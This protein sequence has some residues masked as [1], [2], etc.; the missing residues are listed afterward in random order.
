[1][2][3]LNEEWSHATD[4]L[5]RGSTQTPRAVGEPRRGEMPQE[6]IGQLPHRRHPDR[7][8]T[9][10][11][12][13]PRSR[14]KR[15]SAFSPSAADKGDAESSTD[16]FRVATRSSST[17]ESNANTVF[18]TRDMFLP[19]TSLVW[20]GPAHSRAPSA[21]TFKVSNRVSNVACLTRCSSPATT[22]RLGRTHKHNMMVLAQGIEP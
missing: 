8:G 5:R 21:I 3:I 19:L 22:C 2:R 16:T 14:A 9:A 20:F 17:P 11:R 4:Q 12:S 15:S 7:E 10:S 18:P 13:G 1:M 6:P